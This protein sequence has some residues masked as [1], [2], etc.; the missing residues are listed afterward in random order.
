MTTWTINQLDRNTSDGFVTTVHYSVSKVDGKFSA[1]TYGTVSFEAGTP[2]T[3]FASLTQTQVIEWVKT[4]LDEAV[5]EAALDAQ[6]EAQRNP[7]KA[8]GLP[9]GQA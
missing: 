3:P 7:V 9:W 2:A 6:I 8:S 1:S 4:K 5:V